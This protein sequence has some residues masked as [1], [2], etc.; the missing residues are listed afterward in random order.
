MNS[1]EYVNM[2]FHAVNFDRDSAKSAHCAAK[3]FVQPWTKGVSNQWRTLF[4]GVN[5]VIE[6][7]RV[8]H[9]GDLCRLLRRLGLFFDSYPQARCVRQRLTLCSLLRRLGARYYACTFA[10]SSRVPFLT[11]S[12]HTQSRRQ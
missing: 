7:V 4:G 9:R 10:K 8:G 11:I 2:I 6:E 5:N 1:G 12:L 3:V